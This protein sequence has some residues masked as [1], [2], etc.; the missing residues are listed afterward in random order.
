MPPA[1]S[2]TGYKHLRAA[3]AADEML[4]WEAYVPTPGTATC[5]G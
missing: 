1:D 2:T 5:A 4:L 3:R